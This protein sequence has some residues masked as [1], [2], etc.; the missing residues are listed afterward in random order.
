M[1][2]ISSGTPVRTVRATAN[3][4]VS[5][6][7]L[8]NSTY[9]KEALLANEVVRFQASLI[10]G[11]S[12]GDIKFAFT[13]PAGATII[14][15]FAGGGR[16]DSGG[17]WVSSP[18]VA[19]SSGAALDWVGQNAGVQEFMILIIGSVV[20]G[21]NAGDLQLQFAELVNTATATVYANSTLTTERIT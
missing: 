17:T 10:T 7:T 20:N 5:N 1:I 11:A 15:G 18:V 21:A 14:W 6:T 4:G 16:W 9:L 19:T 3:Q 2:G 12:A 8:T 13:V